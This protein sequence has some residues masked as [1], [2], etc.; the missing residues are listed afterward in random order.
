MLHARCGGVLPHRGPVRLA[1]AVV[2][3]IAADIGFVVVF[4]ASRPFPFP[5]SGLSRGVFLLRSVTGGVLTRRCF[6]KARFL[7]GLWCCGF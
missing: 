3:F 7:A 1:F 2:S 6:R 4:S 5:E